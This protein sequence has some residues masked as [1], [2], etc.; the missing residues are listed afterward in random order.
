MEKLEHDMNDLMDQ[1]NQSWVAAIEEAEKNDS[2]LDMTK[3][4]GKYSAIV[5]KKEKAFQDAKIRM[6]SSK[7]KGGFFL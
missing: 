6:S 1:I 7:K 5:A 2:P 3:M 4:F